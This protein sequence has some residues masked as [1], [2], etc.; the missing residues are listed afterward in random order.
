MPFD[1]LS[2][3][4][5][6]TEAQWASVVAQALGQ[7]PQETRSGGAAR[8]SA[9]AEAPRDT[10][11]TAP[12]ALRVGLLRALAAHD[13]AEF[14]GEAEAVAKDLRALEPVACARLCASLRQFFRAA[15]SD[16]D[17]RALA[18]ARTDA[19]L[20][21]ALDGGRYEL[22]SV[23]RDREFLR[24]ILHLAGEG[25]WV[26]DRQERTTYVNDALASMLGYAKADMLGRRLF[27]FMAGDAAIVAGHNLEKR[28]RGVAERHE[29]P[30][31]HRDGST[32]WTSMSTGP[33]ETPSGEYDG[34]VALVTDLRAARKAQVELQLIA[35]VF[36]C[37]P[38]AIQIFDAD[39]FS[40]RMNEAQ[41]LFLGLDDAQHGVG[42][43]NVLTDPF[44]I[45]SGSAEHFRR[46]YAGETIRHEFRV[47][48][49]RDTRWRT[50]GGARE[51]E[52]LIYPVVSDGGRVMAVV[53]FILD[54]GERRK[55]E[56]A[57]QQG[58][59][60]ES[61]G[62][63]AGGIAHDFN[64]LLVAVIANAELAMRKVEPDSALHELLTGIALAG[65]RAT[66]LTE[67]M[68]A[69]AGRR[70]V[71]VT[72]VRLN[73]LVRELVF[74]LRAS[75]PE[76]AE[77]ELQV[78]SEVPEVVVD[79]AQVRQ[80]AMNLIVN[81]ADALGGR[82]GAIRV[83][84]Y[85]TTI[86]DV[87][88]H[89]TRSGSSRPATAQD[90]PG[91]LTGAPT[92]GEYAALEVED[93]GCGIDPDTLERIFDPFFST[94]P[95][96]RGLGLAA[97]LGIVRAHGGAIAVRSE[98]GKGTCFR[99]LFRAAP[100][101]PGDARRSVKH[102]PEAAKTSLKGEGTV[103]VVDDDPLV[104]AV[105]A[106]A[107][108]LRGFSV[109]EATDGEEALTALDRTRT[110]GDLVALVLDLA[111]PKLGGEHVLA[112]V[113]AV[114]PELPVVVVSGYDEAA[115]AG[116]VRGQRVVFLRKP[117]T[118]SELAASLE[119]AIALRSASVPP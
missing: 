16:E 42:S 89:A 87:S 75:L 63:L 49:S 36:E 32:V 54:I 83:A 65:K 80:V 62:L 29:F 47:D 25:V 34:A 100:P 64:N 92:A 46:A 113:A 67:Q 117:F 40:Y 12:D 115:V 20:A 93:D 45:D 81:A 2:A 90:E 111:M 76:A 4:V 57:V 27:D 59:R 66:E 107:L 96:G 41:R 39:G 9:P 98:P 38:V 101:A 6:E 15:S 119:E 37:A 108:A 8:A 74:L 106:R 110:E 102:A 77:L 78:A 23:A 58:Q 19:L 79:A 3:L 73:E 86:E 112:R 84:T 61:L 82:A 52:Q 91:W 30:L 7:P 18:E 69:Y 17:V 118:E 99:V 11:A 85:R 35:T 68:L 21:A 71:A 48:F 1:R 33:L 55:L 24:R 114:L 72:R 50:R 56:R 14:A 103:L 104:R 31:R 97:V 105:V 5:R 53:S 116:R 94:K 13:D 44:S 95:Q 88:A 43:F 10:R 51:F 60:L 22:G 70:S 28:R 26:I 109:E